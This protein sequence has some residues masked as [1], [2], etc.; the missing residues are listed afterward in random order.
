VIAI[1][2]IYV[3]LLAFF[4]LLM[5]AGGTA[6]LLR[7]VLEVLLAA[8]RTAAVDY[9]RE[10]VSRAGAAA[11]IGLPVWLIH[12]WWAQRLATRATAE[13]ASVLRRLFLYVVLGIALIAMAAGMHEALDEALNGQWRDAL[14][15]L[16]NAAVG[17][18]VWIAHWHV[19]ASDRAAV[20]EEGGSATLR[21][22]YVYAASVVGL[23]WMLSGTR[24]VLEAIWAALAGATSGGITENIPDSVVGLGVWVVHGVLLTTR[25]AEADR[26]STLRSVAAFLSL[27]A[28]IGLTIYNLSQGLYYGLARL[29]GVE[30]PGGVGGSIL[31]AAAGPV[32]GVLVYGAAWFVVARA[33]RGTAEAETPRQIG[34]R[35]LYTYLVALVA[36]VAL[37]VGIAGLLWVL[38]DALTGAPGTATGDWW[39]DKVALFVTLTIVGL[40]LWVLHW[41]PPEL[42]DADEAHSLSRRLYLYLVLIAASLAVLF[43]VAAVAYRLL[44]IL[45]GA[46]ATASL[47]SDLAH[48]A[49]DAVVAGLLVA[50]HVVALRSDM[51]SSPA[52]HS[53][54]VSEVV[55]R[56]RTPAGV[57]LE[58]AFDELRKRGYAVEIVSETPPPERTSPPAV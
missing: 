25:F 24:G 29:F 46:P 10:E 23:L 52:A 47:A 55:V 35:R 19:A 56:L 8:P 7:V 43:S 31:Q 33:T 26:Q 37:T 11:L 38:G 14:S 32:S 16:P 9:V 30:R 41:K 49:A 58:A 57:G 54:P 39:R 40:P 50:Y 51:R 44:T 21:R 5:L 22:W 3:Y 18:V 4:G 12:W 13:R 20:G 42:I 28:I 27:A 15:A 1:R 17:L 36:L 2:R 6:N 45:L 34:T 53:G 48:N